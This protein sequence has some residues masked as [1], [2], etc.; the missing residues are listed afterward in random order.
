MV[1]RLESPVN[2]AQK[3]FINTFLYFLKGRGGDENPHTQQRHSPVF[4]LD[5]KPTVPSTQGL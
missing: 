2:P 3:I 1:K 4:L 5:L